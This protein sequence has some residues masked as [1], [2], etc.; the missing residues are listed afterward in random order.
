MSELIVSSENK[1]K[2]DPE[3]KNLIPPL[4]AEE[5][6]GLEESI[7]QE[8]CRDALI[9]WGDT[10]IDGHNRFEICT[11][12]NI[13]FEVTEMFFPSRDDVKLWM[14]GNQ[15]ARRN[16]NNYARTTLECLSEEIQEKQKERKQKSIDNLRQNAGDR[17]CEITKS[18]E[19]A[20]N[21]AKE[22]AHRANVGEQTASRVMTI[23]KHIEA[24]IANN[25][26]VAGQK[27]EE[28]KR[29]LMN[30]DITVNK[31]YQEL[32]REEKA[33][34]K[35]AAMS[36]LKDKAV[37]DGNVVNGDCIAE[38]EKLA[39]ASVDCVITDPPYGI[40]YVSN[41]RVVDSEVVK[42]VNNDDLQS[43]LKLWEKACEVLSRKMKPDSHIY[44]FTSWKV[45][46]Q[47]A[48][49]TAR[50][51]RIKNCLVW[52][53]NNW[54]M[55]DLDGNYA[56]Q[57]EMAIFATKGNR[58]LNGGRDTNILHYD[59]VANGSLLHS[60]EKP[61]DMLRF[62]ISKSSNPGELVIDPFAGSGSTL[63]ACKREGRAYW[64]CELDSENYKIALGRLADGD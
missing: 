49:I 32:Q 10:L 60:C 26:T 13:P 34:K 16:I 45:Y 4:T 6:A 21:T 53:K 7:L 3:F 37:N 36:E 63:V 35:A 20:V 15:L 61:V 9:V 39:D 62:L 43:A 33:K 22:V 47:F 50:Y 18:V 24:A 46:P 11:R 2:I 12:H 48:E 44:I 30:G 23:N 17:V 55:G 28:L 27:P 57:Y 59:R 1:L 56:E 42:A 52:E 29:Q 54:S 64:G 5:Y 51:F 31:A 40:N 58:K 14:I 19:T 8:G 38:M 25:G 41:F